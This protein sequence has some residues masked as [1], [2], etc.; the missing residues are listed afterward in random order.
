[1]AKTVVPTQGARVQSL[2]GELDPTRGNYRFCSPNGDL[3]QQNKYQKK[4][5]P[6]STFSK[7]EEEARALVIP[8]VWTRCERRL[9][10]QLD[11]PSLL[12][13]SFFKSMKSF[14]ALRGTLTS[15]RIP[16]FAPKSLRTPCAGSWQASQGSRAA[17]KSCFQGS[18][19]ANTATDSPEAAR[20]IPAQLR[21]LGTPALSLFNRETYRHLMARW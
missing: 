6:G 8:L 3:A 2:V 17:D 1:M 9:K 16:S 21:P 7:V 4:K 12:F 15:F 20:L 11:H 10:R 19:A 14:L 13:S 18:P 5:N